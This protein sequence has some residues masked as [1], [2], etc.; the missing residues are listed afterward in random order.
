LEEKWSD[1][2]E[3][4]CVVLMHLWRFVLYL[5]LIIVENK[6]TEEQL[7]YLRQCKYICSTKIYS[8]SNQLDYQINKTPRINELRAIG[9]ELKNESF[10]FFLDLEVSSFVRLFNMY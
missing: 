4:I 7:L 1:L 10:G 5:E 6:L 3:T 8:V 2:K 9:K